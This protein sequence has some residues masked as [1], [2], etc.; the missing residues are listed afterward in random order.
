M[1][2]TYTHNHILM[3]VCVHAGFVPL[4]TNGK[5]ASRRIFAVLLVTRVVH[6]DFVRP[7]TAWVDCLMT[8]K[9]HA[10]SQKSA[11]KPTTWKAVLCGSFI[12]LGRAEIKWAEAGRVMATDA[13]VASINLYS[14]D[15]ENI[16]VI[17]Y[18]PRVAEG[19]R[20]STTY[21]GP[22]LIEGEHDQNVSEHNEEEDRVSEY[23]D[24]EAE[25]FDEEQLEAAE[26]EGAE[27]SAV[28]HEYSD[29]SEATETDENEDEEMRSRDAEDEG[30]DALDIL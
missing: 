26:S 10:V 20:M 12:V 14:R 11:K 3:R 6:V 5:G 30:D 23:E 19:A 18:R 27:E 8:A 4:Y 29:D 28:E 1:C 7:H 16:P 25:E 24:S 13:G 17:V 22:G 15:F 9:E 21:T 2:T